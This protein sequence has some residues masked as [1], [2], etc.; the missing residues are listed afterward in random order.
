MNRPLFSIA[1]PVRNGANFLAEALESVAAQSFSDF[2]LVV[3]DNVSTDAT[4]DILEAFCGRDSR[5]RWSRSPDSLPVVENFNRAGSLAR[6]EWIVFLSHDDMLRPTCLEQLASALEEHGE[7]PLGLVG[8]AEEHVFANGYVHV[9]AWSEATRL[10][11]F[12]GP[13]FLRRK[14]SGRS[15]APLPG[16]SNAAVRRSVWEACGRFDPRF[17]HCDT[18]LWHRIL[19]HHDY[20]A[21][22]E[23]LVAVR[24]HEQQDSASVRRQF[25]SIDEFR[26]FFPEFVRDNADRLELSAQDRHFAE[27]LYLSV[28]ATEMVIQILRRDV[29]RAWQILRRVPWT[30]YPWMAALVVRNGLREAA[31]TRHV[32]RH[33]PT[34][35]VYPG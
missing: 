14:L 26:T 31:R 33:V 1:M 11:R 32:R 8:F 35:M 17:L 29:R 4:P 19:L 9:P 10:R 22:S 18:F 2:E 16:M 25:R 12:A 13:A 34:R 3:S 21:I 6:G 23:P 7:P 27:R 20:L 24:I 28:A 5:F 30:Q 15:P